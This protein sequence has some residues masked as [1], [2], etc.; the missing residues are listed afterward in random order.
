M[1][2][3]RALLARC[4]PCATHESSHVIGGWQL[5][6][7]PESCGWEPVGQLPLDRYFHALVPHGDTELLAVGGAI[8][9]EA[10]PL[11][12]IEAVALP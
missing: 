10:D 7:P 12:T 11:A 2:K 5:T 3:R 1:S 9:R 6:G 4:V 8:G